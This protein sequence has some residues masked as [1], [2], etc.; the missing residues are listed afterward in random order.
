MQ[1]P[2]WTIKLKIGSGFFVAGIMLIICGMAGLY[3]SSSLS[4]SLSNFTGPVLQTTSNAN[5]GMLSVQSQLIAVQDI[6]SGSSDANTQN[7]LKQAEDTARQTL[8][9]IRQAQQVSDEEIG[10]LQQKMN[11]FSEAKESLLKVHDDFVKLEND[12]DK[13]VSELL[14]FIIDIERLASQALLESQMQFEGEDVASSQPAAIL[15]DGIRQKSEGARHF[16]A[17]EESEVMAEAVSEV[18]A[19][20]SADI[21]TDINTDIN[22]GEALAETLDE[23]TLDESAADDVSEE[24]YVE[25][26]EYDEEIDAATQAAEELVQANQ[27]LVNSASEARLALLNRLNLLNRFR[28]DTKDKDVI[29]RLK[30]V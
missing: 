4:V 19:D 25:E 1:V 17:V 13:T 22:S 3:L 9:G 5:S 6:L 24:A 7:R 10:Q 16:Y 27:D 30:Q 26:S 29:Q 8:E 18:G 23:S 14:D 2:K 21:N 28:T 15:I 12:I 11:S 20:E